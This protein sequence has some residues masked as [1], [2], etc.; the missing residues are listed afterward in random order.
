MSFDFVVLT[1]PTRQIA[2]VYTTLC[3][4]LKQKVSLLTCTTIYC[5]ADPSGERIGS[6]GGTLNAIDYL[7]QQVG[8]IVISKSKTAIIHSGGD[9][10]RAPLHSVCGKAWSSLNAV[11]DDNVIA[12]PIALLLAELSRFSEDLPAGSVV[13]ASS[14]V[15]LNICCDKGAP[16]IPT[17]SVSIVT[18]P[19]SPEVAKNHG[20][21]VKRSAFWE[22]NGYSAGNS[23]LYLQKP[24][25]D[26][27]E[28]SGAIQKSNGVQ[29]TLIDTGVVIFSG[30]ALE[31]L[32]TL[33]D[34]AIISRCTTRGLS[35]VP[36]DSQQ[37]NG[38]GNGNGTVA[39]LGGKI[40]QALRL[41]LYSDILLCLALENGA[42]TFAEYC[43]KVGANAA[44]V[45]Q[46]CMKDTETNTTIDHFS[47]SEMYLLAI[48]KLHD[49]LS[50]IPL[51]TMSVEKGAFSHLGTSAEL[52]DLLTFPTNKRMQNASMTTDIEKI[53]SPISEKMAPLSTRISE[54]LTPISDT[55][56]PVSESITGTFQYMYKMTGADS[57]TGVIPAKDEW[58]AERKIELF[59]KKYG[60][61]QHALGAI[62]NING[63]HDD[64]PGAAEEL[65]AVTINSVLL[66]SGRG[67][68]DEK[69]ADPVGP[70]SPDNEKVGKATAK[71]AT[72]RCSLIE[73][74]CLTGSFRV[75]SRATVSHISPSL[76]EDLVVMDDILMQQVPLQDG[77]VPD[78]HTP[79]PTYTNTGR[80]FSVLL[81]LGLHDDVKAA[82]QSEQA[83]VC[84]VSWHT[85]FE[86]RRTQA[87]MHVI[88]SWMLRRKEMYTYT[89]HQM[90]FIY[91][92]IYLYMYAYVHLH[93]CAHTSLES[94]LNLSTSYITY[95]TTCCSMYP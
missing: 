85:F 67:D 65:E 13:V 92:C 94:T 28:K 84:G 83:T 58:E 20:V 59:A 23:A 8:N 47:S 43:D 66:A 81:I 16:K 73:H 74:S 62:M 3:N 72:K 19:E 53:M 77:V 82:A 90:A 6:G 15:L 11:H 75:G 2:E 95:I 30:K 38:N 17:D 61:A 57:V 35:K 87:I 50:T 49:T 80:S 9:S 4:H 40:T 14:D 60:L 64:S 24:S 12:T 55:L 68:N 63:E 21:L 76:G 29:R 39:R 79:I 37:S 34:D 88:R 70:V 93:V 32:L 48:K 45:E 54:T 36:G 71:S 10:R 5:V 33:L 22:A 86:V 31:S 69:T 91:L 26:E 27:M 41:E 52:L 1:A 7:Q 18:V 44:E 51:V 78:E 25:V 89:I 56:A 42:C 46:A